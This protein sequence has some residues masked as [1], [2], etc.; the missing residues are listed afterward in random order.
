MAIQCTVHVR[1]NSLL[2]RQGVWFR[3]A[4]AVYREIIL[5]HDRHELASFRISTRSV[6]KLLL[7][8]KGQSSLQ[9]LITV[10]TARA[11]GLSGVR[12]ANSG[13]SKAI[14]VNRDI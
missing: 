3:A 11:G 14:V 1:T 8:V 12:V 10:P 7:S 4:G 5:R 6:V 13:A 2:I 9:G